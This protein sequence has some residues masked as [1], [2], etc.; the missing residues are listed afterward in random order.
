[1]TPSGQSPPATGLSQN[2]SPLVG[3]A[4]RGVSRAK[5]LRA[6]SSPVER[7]MWRILWGFRTNGYHFRKQAKIGPYTVDMAC[8][9]AKL[10]IEVDGATHGTDA[11]QRQDARRDAFLKA[12]GYT[13]LRIPNREVL[14]N[15]D[16]VYDAV[17]HALVGRPKNRRSAH[18]LPNPPHKGEGARKNRQPKADPNRAAASQDTGNKALSQDTSP[19][20]GGGRE[21]GGQ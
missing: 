21:G 20:G 9:H 4:G 17:A 5:Q 12:E 8:H 13:V 18:P 1:M 10:V 14:R 19:L 16:G 7:R 15:P 3:E 11:A 2:T 6:N